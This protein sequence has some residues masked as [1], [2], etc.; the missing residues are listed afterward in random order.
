MP[1]PPYSAVSSVSDIGSVDQPPEEAFEQNRVIMED[2]TRRVKVQR[3][4]GPAMK[5][6][7]I[8]V[9]PRKITVQGDGMMEGGS[10][11]DVAPH[12]SSQSHTMA[13]QEDEEDEEDE[14]DD[15]DQCSNPNQ[16][17]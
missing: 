8:T 4:A 6:E 1:S 13:G 14:G 12:M 5:R 10:R 9:D 15:E 7:E 3:K 16:C 17:L 2:G 11:P